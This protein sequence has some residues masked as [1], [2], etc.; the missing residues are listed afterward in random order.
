[1]KNFE[2]TIEGKQYNIPCDPPADI[3]F[4]V[5]YV[6]NRY[7]KDPQEAFKNPKPIIEVALR[8][9]QLADS[10]VKKIEPTTSELL[11]LVNKVGKYFTFGMKSKK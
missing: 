5:I 11:D 9:V 2:I 1:M 6:F 3:G 8:L 4:K 7:N 10:T